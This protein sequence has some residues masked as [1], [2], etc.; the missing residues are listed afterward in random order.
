MV[1]VLRV[2]GVPII[3]AI[4]QEELA[5]AVADEA[6]VVEGFSLL[7]ARVMPGSVARKHQDVMPPTESLGR[8]SW[9]GKHWNRIKSLTLM[10]LTLPGS[11]NAG[12]TPE[13][14]AS[15]TCA[16][17]YRYEEYRSAMGD[18]ALGKKEFDTLFIP[19]NINHRSG[20]AQQLLEGSRWFH[21][22][23]C[24][25]N[26]P[27]ALE[28]DLGN[29]FH[30][31]RGYTS[32]ES[33][34]QSLGVMGEFLKKNKKEVLV[35]GFN[36]I[37]SNFGDVGQTQIVALAAQVLKMLL[38]FD[39]GH[40][41][42]SE[43]KTKTLESL[44]ASNQRV[45]IFFEGVAS[46]LPDGVL[47]SR[48]LLLEGWDNAMASGNLA[49]SEAW[50]EDDLKKNAIKQDRFY[51]MQANPNNAED[52]MYRLLGENPAS[53][54]VWE[55]PFLLGL[56]RLIFEVVAEE[57]NVRINVVSTDLFGVSQP[58]QIAMELNGLP[59]DLDGEVP[60]ETTNAACLNPSVISETFANSDVNPLEFELQAAHVMQRHMDRW[61]YQHDLIDNQCW[62]Q[63]LNSSE[64]SAP[65]EAQL[66]DFGEQMRLHTVWNE[67]SGTDPYASPLSGSCQ[68]PGG[69]PQGT[70]QGFWHARRWGKMLREQYSGL[71]S[72]S[73]PAGLIKL[74][75]DDVHKNELTLQ[76]EYEAICG[77][78]PSLQEFP[79]EEVEVSG[80]IAKG[81]PWYMDSNMCGG[82]RIRDL[83]QEAEAAKKE[84]AWWNTDVQR[85]AA[86]LAEAVG[87][88]QPSFDEAAEFLDNIMDCAVVHA[89]TGL[90]DTP[91][92]LLDAN[93]LPD[94]GQDALF[95]RTNRNE[96]LDRTWGF[97]YWRA[98]NETVFVEYASLYY[99]Y[100]F[101]VLSDQLRAAVDGK[102]GAPRLT[103]TV[104]SDSNISPQLALYNLT[105]FARQ[106]PPYLSALIHEIYKDKVGESYVRVVFNGAV[107]RVCPE[108]ESFPLCPLSEWAELVAKFQP[109]QIAC[110][111]L[112]QNYE[113]L[114][115]V[116]A[117]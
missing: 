27:D 23:I 28:P 66:C 7:H 107:V 40:I 90:E 41:C 24:N 11:H 48:D 32:P 100:F 85:V 50:L 94:M 86:E 51:V 36:N 43:L 88:E 95:G 113:F 56:R 109:S 47:A 98:K 112:Y 78:L 5:A 72:T 111:T 104:M 79:K 92:A 61:I 53:L 83:M 75:A 21:L 116:I 117:K 62:P 2:L 105:D 71:I 96:T 55:K 63:Q 20:I 26:M 15:R 82:D 84:S 68:V 37:H 81:R 35:L 99:G 49:A 115:N 4:G 3:A 8:G 39:I 74:H 97:D 77:R 30:S 13:L 93:G 114:S 22:K 25:F 54:E 106:R 102:L 44:I 19:W 29:V 38:Q 59:T 45:A 60:L 1:W 101:S 70:W 110:P 12:N 46:E 69:I 89:C 9:M 52:V 57:P 16:T 64:F 33:L 6:T 80:E 103:I 17:D 34:S 108:V 87:K 58:Y 91:A 42:R 14:S 10:N 67:W 18:A 65:L 73:C 31:H 76:T